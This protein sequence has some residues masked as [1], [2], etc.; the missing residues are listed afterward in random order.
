MNKSGVKRMIQDIHAISGT[1]EIISI[2]IDKVAI[3]IGSSP[4]V[5]RNVEVTGSVDSLVPGSMVNIIWVNRR[6]VV[7]SGGYSDSGAASSGPV[8]SS[9]FFTSWTTWSPTFTGFSTSPSGTFRY[10]QLG[11]VVI[12]TVECSTAGTSSG[13]G[14]SMTAPVLSANITGCVWR[15]EAVSVDSGTVQTTPGRVTLGAN[16]NIINVLKAWDST[17]LWT[18][19]LGKS[20][21][22]TLIYEAA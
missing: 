3:R 2:E 18:A 10:C 22:F 9:M 17:V 13:T 16:T 14:F 20:S 4:N 15:A 6:P 8:S 21:R 1:A 11:K 5:I 19:S 12:C 7:V